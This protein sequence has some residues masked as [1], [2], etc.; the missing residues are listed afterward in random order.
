[1]EIFQRLKLVRDVF[2]EREKE[3]AKTQKEKIFSQ[4]TELD[5]KR[6]ED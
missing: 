5:K 2:V 6:L 3:R 1:M 4:F